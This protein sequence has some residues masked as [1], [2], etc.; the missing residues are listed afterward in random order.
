M[1]DN[2]A[3]DNI[4]FLASAIS[5]NLLLAAVPFALLFAAGLSYFLNLSPATASEELR[6]IVYTMLPVASETASDPL[7]RILTGIVNQR[8]TVT[9]LSAIGF[10]WFT[11]RLFGSLRSVLAEV[12]DIEQDRG[13]VEGKIFDVKITIV[14][15]LLLVGY[16]VLTAYLAFAT[17]R[18]IVVLSE[19]GLRSDVMGGV[20]YWIGRLL[21][22]A[23]ITVLF[24]ALYKFLPNRR[25]RWKMAMMGALFGATMFEIARQLFPQIVARLPVGSLYTG[26]IAAVI[27]TVVWVYYGSLIFILGGEL[28]QVY[29]LRRM[30]RLQ[31]EAFED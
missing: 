30:R 8:G 27:I 1:W 11:T 5:F 17:T 18:G 16:T 26:T 2:G 10:I 4:F 20:E 31:R 15:M 13:I 29:Q 12:F 14:A 3:E 6:H 7:I 28:G 22:F 24:F 19:L 9:L 25:I 23:S 21:G